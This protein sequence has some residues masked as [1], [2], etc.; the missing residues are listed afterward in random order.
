MNRGK[1]G[2][3]ALEISHE[4]K[5]A[6]RRGRSKLAQCDG[7][8]PRFLLPQFQPF[9]S[10][11]FSELGQDLR[12][13]FPINRLTINYP[14]NHYYTSDVEENHHCLHLRLAH[15]C[16]SNLLWFDVFQCIDCLLASAV[17]S[18]THTKWILA[19]LNFYSTQRIRQN[20][21]TQSHSNKAHRQ[22]NWYKLTSPVSFDSRSSRSI[23]F[24][25]LRSR[26]CAVCPVSNSH[27]SHLRWLIFE[28]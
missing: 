15:S 3:R 24:H 4:L 14:L 1:G 6:W 26:A 8:D 25:S 22:I 19:L 28:L 27:I 13:L 7:V 9:L 20:N 12:A 17:V 16:S 5:I 21:T 2:V 11:F 23:T 18:I 10:Q